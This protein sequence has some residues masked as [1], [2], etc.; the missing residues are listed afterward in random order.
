MLPD[1]R[2]R[3]DDLKLSEEQELELL[4]TSLSLDH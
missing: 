1:V 4:M 2:N 3:E